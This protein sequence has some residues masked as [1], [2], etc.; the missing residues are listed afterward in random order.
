[1]I[2]VEKSLWMKGWKVPMDEKEKGGK[3][4][5]CDKEKGGKVPMVWIAVEKSAY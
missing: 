2:R 4:P 3:V 5:M 1:M